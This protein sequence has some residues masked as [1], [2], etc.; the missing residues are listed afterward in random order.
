MSMNSR[1]ERSRIKKR[2]RNP[3]YFFMIEKKNE[4][5]AEHR[6]KSEWSNE[7]LVKIIMPIWYRNKDDP[8]F[9]EPYINMHQEW[10]LNKVGL[11]AFF[12]SRDLSFN[13][14]D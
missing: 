14:S 5:I 2:T 13:S 7:K 12:I 10:K 6:W 11:S 4:M 3:F 8:S 9:M 1:G